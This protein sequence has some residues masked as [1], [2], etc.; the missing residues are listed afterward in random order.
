MTEAPPEQISVPPSVVAIVRGETVTQLPDDLF[1]PPDALEVILEAFEGPLDLL[2]YLIRKN[3]FNI[4]DIPIA[5]IT[6]Q[7]MSYVELMKEL[8][9]ELAAEYLVMAAMLA[10]IKS[11]LL[12]PRP[13][14]VEDEDDPRAELIRRLQAYEQIKQAAQDVDAMPREEREIFVVQATPPDLELQRPHPDVDIRELVSAF[15]A[16]LDR[17]EHFTEHHIARD[18]ISVRARMAEIL[19]DLSTDSFV[20]FGSLFR[21]GEGRAGLVANFIAILELVKESLLELVQQAP[22]APIHVRAAGRH[23]LAPN[24]NEEQDDYN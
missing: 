6:E 20:E 2:L 5:D 12:L 16:V 13:V 8:R 3:N 18:S 22:F 23:Q 4:V 17:S 19:A 1:I 10:E 7:Y 14:T 24:F 21:K 11:R 15:Q 9:L